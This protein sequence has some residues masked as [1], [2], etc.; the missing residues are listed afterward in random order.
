MIQEDFTHTNVT[1]F[2]FRRSFFVYNSIWD[3]LDFSPLTKF[4]FTES[5]NDFTSV[6]NR[7]HITKFLFI[8]YLPRE[9]LLLSTVSIFQQ[10]RTDALQDVGR[11]L[12]Q[13]Y[14][15]EVLKYFPKLA[16]WEQ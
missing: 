6:R 3:P 13:W 5:F 14:S 7:N 10:E 4:F 11:T 2:Y 15:N 1:R 12:K 8:S 9:L 16:I